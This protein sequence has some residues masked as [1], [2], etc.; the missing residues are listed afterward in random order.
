MKK[1]FNLKILNITLWINLI[2]TVIYPLKNTNTGF[3]FGFPLKYL[4]LHPQDLDKTFLSGFGINVLSLVQNIIF[5][6]IIF[7][8]L[9][10]IFEK[11]NK[12]YKNSR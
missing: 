12:Y 1:F 10:I 5:F 9:K 11:L 3:E 6:Y 7:L 2:L 4:S 8:I